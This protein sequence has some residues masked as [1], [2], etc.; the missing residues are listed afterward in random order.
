LKKSSFL[1]VVCLLFLGYQSIKRVDLVQDQSFIV[2]K[3]AVARVNNDHLDNLFSI[4]LENYQD[5]P[6]YRKLDDISE[7]AGIS[8][9]ML[10]IFIFQIILTIIIIF[11][12]FSIIKKLKSQ[13]EIQKILEATNQELIQEIQE[14]ITMEKAL[15]SSEKRLQL[16]LES[17]GDG[18]WD[19]NIVTG[20]VY[21]SPRWLQMLEYRL[22]ELP[23]NV[24]TWENSIHPEDRSWV[25]KKLHS[26]LEDESFPY[27]FDYRL[28]T[29]SGGWKWI[30]NYGK[31]VE[32]DQNGK[33]V[34]MVGLHKDISDRK[35]L[36]NVL[37][38]QA[39]REST[40]ARILE[41]IRLSLDIETIFQTTSQELRLL[42]KCDRLIIYQLDPNQLIV[43]SFDP[44]ETPWS[45]QNLD[46]IWE[47]QRENYH[48][49]QTIVI[50]NLEDSNLEQKQDIFQQLQIKSYLN[51][52]IFV[53][54]QK[55]GICIAYRIKNTRPW[56]ETE[57]KLLEQISHYFGVAIQQAE[58]L[59]KLQEAKEIADRANQA[60]S[61]FLANMSH[62]LRTPLNAILGFVQILNS[63]TEYNQF[64]PNEKE[65][66][67][68]IRNSG[69][70]LLKLINEI[71]D[72][73][74]IEAG[75]V[76][77]YKNSF[78][79]YLL[80]ENLAEMFRLK[81][82]DKRLDLKFNLDI[83]ISPYIKT[84]ENK[85]RQVVIN[86]LENAIKY[87]D[88]GEINLTVTAI[89]PTEISFEVQDT[90]PGISPEETEALFQPFM[91]TEVG[92]KSHK[93]TGLGLPIS[94]KF[95]QL[96]GGD[97]TFNCP[98][99]G[100]TIFQFQIPVD[101]VNLNETHSMQ[102]Q[103]QQRVIGL[104]P[105]QP[106]YKILVVEDKYANR[107][108]M[109]NLLT[110]VGFRVKEATNGQEAIAIWQE[111]KPDLIW[112]DMRMPIMDGYEATKQIKA[113][114]EGEKTIIIAL[115]ASAFNEESSQFLSIGC[116][117]FVAKPIEI[118][119]IF[120]KMSQHLGVKYIY[121]MSTTLEQKPEYQPI[122]E[123]SRIYQ[124]I[125][126]QMPENWLQQ[127]QQAASSLEDDKIRSLIGEI[128]PSHLIL[129]KT[130]SDFNQKLRFDKILELLNEQSPT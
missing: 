50:N 128:P 37:R 114:P 52:P 10:T 47:T 77:L 64:S 17:S 55:W 120:S 86:L 36:E 85:L 127:L 56:Q 112:M 119:L 13:E 123:R 33:P 48:N 98:P 53:G 70:Y 49:H 111:W 107:L 30:A 39:E 34:R 51:V 91:Q 11:W 109:V 72:M 113:T 68:I 23:E 71:L 4:F 118:N 46:Q 27:H 44:N 3:T 26:H 129:R 38:T 14:R 76:A 63:Q 101:P 58:L 102:P 12:R 62:E 7:V 94:R 15:I 60:K 90:G 45:N 125:L 24:S 41:R 79:I 124:E 43:E 82:L 104:A 65:Y 67:T 115:S 25:M 73:S 59:Q 1:T 6:Y 81:A 75:K 87:T 126:Q 100:G 8:Y 95:V 22:G 28:K 5:E 78:N 108:L 103:T 83:N 9:K 40:I 19:W 42:L 93:G 88:K 54:E 97:L 116:D 18:L 29:K 32:R 84:D 117:D 74:K 130:L 16:A 31:V 92:K 69:E 122:R 89:S 80:M 106:N 99:E 35:A 20:E 96:M 2:E 110:S 105:H 57:I 66:L 121:E 61:E 21:L